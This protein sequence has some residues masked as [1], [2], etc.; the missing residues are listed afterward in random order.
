MLKGWFDRVLVY[1]EVYT[2]RKRFE[3]GRFAGKRACCR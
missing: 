3:H 2:S 1:G